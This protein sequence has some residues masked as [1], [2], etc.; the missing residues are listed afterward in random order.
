MPAKLT[1]DAPQTKEVMIFNSTTST[2]TPTLHPFPH[3]VL[4][5]ICGGG[6]VN[7]VCG[8]GTPIVSIDAVGAMAGAGRRGA[9][10]A[11]NGPC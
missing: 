3:F 9:G 1:N 7:S 6:G 10:A 4:T 5:G 8:G 2:S 11:S